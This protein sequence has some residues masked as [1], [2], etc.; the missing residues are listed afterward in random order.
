V[1]LLADSGWFI[2]GLVVGAAIGFMLGL[3][4][5]RYLQQQQQPVQPPMSA[6]VVFDRDEAG[7]ITGIHYVGGG[8]NG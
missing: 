2:A 1:G 3:S 8:K 5:S 7:K 4:L 6:S